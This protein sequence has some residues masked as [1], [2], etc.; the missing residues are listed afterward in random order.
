[1]AYLN[2]INTEEC[3]SNAGQVDSQV[4][5]CKVSANSLLTVLPLLPGLLHDGF[6]ITSIIINSSPALSCHNLELSLRALAATVRES[7]LEQPGVAALA[8]AAA[9]VAEVAASNGR[10][11]YVKTAGVIARKTVKA[12][13][14][15]SSIL[16]GIVSSE[17]SDKASAVAMATGIAGAQGDAAMAELLNLDKPYLQF[18]SV[19]LTSLKVL[20]WPGHQQE[21]PASEDRICQSAAIALDAAVGLH[22]AV[23][24]SSAT[25]N[26]SP[27]SGGMGK[28]SAGS[29][30][31][32]LLVLAARSCIAF[33]NSLL[34]LLSNM[35]SDL[36][37]TTGS[38]AAADGMQATAMFVTKHSTDWP[39]C[40]VQIADALPFVA[41]ELQQ[42]LSLIASDTT[43]T[44]A[45]ALACDMHSCTTAV[46]NSKAVSD[47]TALGC[48]V[49]IEGRVL[50]LPLGDMQPMLE[51]MKTVSQGCKVL[52][53]QLL[54]QEEGAATR[55]RAAASRLKSLNAR[56]LAQQLQ[57]LGSS[58]C[59]ALPVAC[60]CNNPGCC[61]FRG[62]SELQLV[63]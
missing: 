18:F 1:M 49:D 61:T 45:P 13:L 15:F 58:L 54:L 22:A 30:Q 56:Q 2:Q 11:A 10:V 14:Q 38:S 57:Q 39:D 63:T 50:Q 16:T 17:S 53:Q 32:A 59:A 55:G 34:A 27:S 60:C 48:V 21:P 25:S 28:E 40:F 37:T 35:D 31:Q 8:P 26:R 24:S 5:D 46:H 41:Q 42:H 47:S 23:L 43:A 44:H 4:H 6:S 62:N 33:G 7:A 19:L 20:C 52:Q 12:F 36:Q 3:C 9:A 29:V 51:Q